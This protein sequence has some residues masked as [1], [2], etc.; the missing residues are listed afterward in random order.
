[1]CYQTT[2][3]T[4][5]TRSNF[6]HDVSEGWI[7][8]RSAIRGPP[9]E[10]GGAATN[11]P[12]AADCRL[13]VPSVFHSR[14]KGRQSSRKKSLLGISGRCS[15]SPRRLSAHTNGRG[16]PHCRRARPNP[17]VSKLNTNVSA[18][19]GVGPDPP[20]ATS[21][22]SLPFGAVTNWPSDFAR[23]LKKPLRGTM[24]NSALNRGALGT[25]P[26]RTALPAGGLSSGAT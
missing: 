22:D 10:V 26:V 11:L 9:N 12:F 7:S 13:N 25:D 4:A 3:L 8:S 6:S 14:V 1:M 23:R 18:H 21:G 24:S 17:L 5:L 15:W 2:P 20:E 16:V 19:A